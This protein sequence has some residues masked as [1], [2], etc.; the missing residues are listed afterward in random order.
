MSEAVAPVYWLCANSHCSEIKSETVCNKTEVMTDTYEENPF[1]LLLF[2]PLFAAISV[3][4]FILKRQMRKNLSSQKQDSIL[5]V[6]G[7]NV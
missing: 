6:F 4:L 3:V 2:A 1:Y 7:E 5:N